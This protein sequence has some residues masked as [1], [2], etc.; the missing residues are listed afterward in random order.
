MTARGYGCCIWVTRLGS[1]IAAVFCGRQTGVFMKTKESLLP[2]L[3]NAAYTEKELAD[4][5][6]QIEQLRASVPETI[7]TRL[8]PLSHKL[9]AAHHRAAAVKYQLL[10]LFHT[11]P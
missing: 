2:I 11:A 4:I 1:N 9:R 8:I 7:E 10:A 6:Q 5:V 3:W